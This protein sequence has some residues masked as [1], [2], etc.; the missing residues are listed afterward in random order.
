MRKLGVIPA[1]YSSTRLPGKPLEQIGGKSMIQRVFERSL[2]AFNADELYIATDDERI[3][4]HVKTFTQNVLMTSDQHTNGTERVAEVV[5]ILNFEGV[6]IN[7]QGDEPF[8]DPIAVTQVINAFS[9]SSTEIASLY[10]K[11][12]NMNEIESDSVIK[13]VID[14]HGNAL[15]FSRAPIPYYRD[16]QQE[17]IYYRHVGLYGFTSDVLTKLVRLP[18]SDLERA[19]SLEQLRW[20]E[21][22]FRI[23]MTETHHQSESVDTQQDL[24]RIRNNWALGMYEN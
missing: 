1:R 18:V 16:V 21:N 3:F 5:S 4:N 7:I 9:N 13:V 12:E 19:E 15:Y 23:K 6:V 24:T 14:Y 17:K 8:I 11:C 10:R 20:L 2:H 22:G